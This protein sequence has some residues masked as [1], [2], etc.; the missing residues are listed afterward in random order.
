MGQPGVHVWD[1]P[2]RPDSTRLDIERYSVLLIRAANT[3]LQPFRLDESALCK[4]IFYPG[5]ARQSSVKALRLF[6]KAF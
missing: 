2:A 5:L 6:E 3:L 1:L 4:Q